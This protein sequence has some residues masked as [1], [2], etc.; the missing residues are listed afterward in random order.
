MDK[1]RLDEFRD[2]N[3]VQAKELEEAQGTVKKGER[4]DIER[5]KLIEA[6]EVEKLIT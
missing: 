4:E 5:K 1:S 3:I 2:R 6:G